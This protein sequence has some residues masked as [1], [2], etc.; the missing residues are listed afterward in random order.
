MPSVNP[1]IALT[2]PPHRYDLLTRLAKL[3][4]N[5]RAG[6]ITETMEL[7]YP[8]LERVCV[9]LE[10]AHKAQESSQQ[11]LRDAVSQA[12]TELMPLLYEAAS[13][14][15]LFMDQAGATVGAPPVNPAMDQV[16]QIMKASSPVAAGGSR[17]CRGPLPRSSLTPSCDTGSGSSPKGVTH[18]MRLHQGNIPR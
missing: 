3:Q 16:R 11:G 13:Q 4:G 8:V 2:L 9:V 1:R 12:E 7:V 6:I 10:A 18:A 17:R 5:S 15:D 14:F